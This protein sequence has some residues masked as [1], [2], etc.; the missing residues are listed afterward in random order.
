V[1]NTP[2]SGGP[3]PNEASPSDSI[4]VEGTMKPKDTYVGGSKTF[5]LAPPVATSGMTITHKLTVHWHLHKLD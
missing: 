3:Y 4:Q 1:I 2:M 5:D